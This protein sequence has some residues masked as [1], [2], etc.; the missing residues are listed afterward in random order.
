MRK[1]IAILA[2]TSVLIL[3]LSGCA[4][5]HQWKSATCTEPKKCLKCN[6]T[7]KEPLGHAWNKGICGDFKSCKRCQVIGDAADSTTHQWTD[8]TC[9]EPKRC[10]IC[11]EIEGEPL[12]H[13]WGDVQK[14]WLDPKQ[15]DYRICLECDFKEFL[16]ADSRYCLVED[17]PNSKKNKCGY[18]N[19]H[20]LDYCTD[21]YCTH[22]KCKASDC[23]DPG[24]LDGYCN[25]HYYEKARNESRA[26]DAAKEKQEDSMAYR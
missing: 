17:C 1:E 25:I 9:Q 11:G 21:E 6:K 24:N 8:A 26:R 12:G 4:C 14:D 10:E 23:K 7:E 20:H 5:E 3:C 22:D 16:E 13:T 19:S 2:I 15:R 18:C